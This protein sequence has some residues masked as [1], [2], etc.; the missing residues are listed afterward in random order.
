MDRENGPKRV[1]STQ[2]ANGGALC[3]DRGYTSL[4]ARSIPALNPGDHSLRLSVTR[5]YFYART[6]IDPT[7]NRLSGFWHV[8]IAKGG[9]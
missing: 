8:R 6:V 2:R 9:A 3:Q 7:G 1:R 4:P 5:P